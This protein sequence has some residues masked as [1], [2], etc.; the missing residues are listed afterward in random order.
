MQPSLPP[1]RLIGIVQVQLAEISP[2]FK[3]IERLAPGIENHLFG[4]VM[5]GL[6]D[7]AWALAERCW[8]VKVPA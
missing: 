8:L 3:D 2:T 5:K 6:R 7:G 4:E 1:T